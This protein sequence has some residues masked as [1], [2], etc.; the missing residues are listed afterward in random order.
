MCKFTES[1]SDDF[2]YIL[3]IIVADRSNFDVCKK[4]KVTM[5]NKIW[6]PKVYYNIDNINDF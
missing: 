1:S 2:H 4:K 5:N 3:T 6:C